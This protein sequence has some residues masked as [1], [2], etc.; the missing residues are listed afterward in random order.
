MGQIHWGG[1]LLSR[2]LYSAVFFGCIGAISLAQNPPGFQ[3]EVNL[4]TLDVSATEKGTGRILEFLL[5]DDFEVTDNGKLFTISN[6]GFAA[7]PLDIVFLAYG[8]LGVTA[9]QRNRTVKAF[10]E[11]LDTLKDGDRAAVVVGDWLSNAKTQVPMTEDRTMIWNTIMPAGGRTHFSLF[12]GD[13]VYEALGVSVAAF[14]PRGVKNRGRAIIAMTTDRERRS[15]TN[16]ERLITDLLE[17]DTT[18]CAGLIDGD[19][20]GRIAIG[21]PPGRSGRE[22]R[23]GGVPDGLHSI[24]PIVEATGGDVLGPDE[25]EGLPDLV[26]RL[27]PRYLLQF[28]ADPEGSPG[29]HRIEVRLSADAQRRYSGA[30]LRTRRGYQ[31]KS[32]VPAA[33]ARD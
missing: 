27:K 20:G 15:A 7:S 31:L 21:G 18:V 1:F 22:I 28:Y 25:I 9:K 33:T 4:V 5:K 13:R 10:R 29:F 24:R 6:F 26:A 16:P 2:A 12:P 19:P 30:L 23:V 11:A 17:A 3:A 14:P 8:Q 32:T